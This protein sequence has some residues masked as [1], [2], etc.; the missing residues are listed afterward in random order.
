MKKGTD[1]PDFNDLKSAVRRGETARLYVLTGEEDFLAE[2]LV[3]TILSTLLQPGFEAVDCV[4]LDGSSRTSRPDIDRLER[5]AS[6]PAFASSRRVVVVRQSGLFAGRPSKA[7]RDAE[8]EEDGGEDGN[9]PV[10]AA[11]GDQTTRL[12]RLMENLSDGCCFLFLEE[13][14]DRRQRALLDA[15]RT[16]GVFASFDRQKPAELTAWL[17]GLCRKAGISIDRRA[18]ESLVDRCDNSMRQIRSECSKLLLFCTAESR[19][20]I[21]LGLVDALC[22]QDVRGGIFDL[23]DAIAAGRTERAAAL[24]DALLFR[25]EP[26]TLIRFLLARH[27]RNLLVVSECATDSQA[28]TQAGVPS[29][30]A[31]RLRAQ[32]RSMGTDPLE[33]LY[34][35]CQENDQAVKSGRMPDVLA[36]ETLVISACELFGR[37]I[38]LKTRATHNI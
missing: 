23:T 32:V 20:S 13:K 11:S 8:T 31:S 15:I 34:I 24:L 1:N 2:N 16:H 37:R 29:F 36:L 7:S 33:R 25:K 17:T 3:S 26:T 28:A 18:A 4:R 19:T 30:V 35:R 6:T 38:D 5:E 22:V 10:R 21:D 12:I 27:I 14:V 9:G